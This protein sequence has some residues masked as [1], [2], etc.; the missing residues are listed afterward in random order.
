[1]NDKE[2]DLN[3][4]IKLVDDTNQTPRVEENKKDQEYMKGASDEK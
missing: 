2:D 1:M 3:F 4:G